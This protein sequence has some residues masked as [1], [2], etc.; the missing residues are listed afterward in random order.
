MFQK[1]WKIPKKQDRY[2][3]DKGIII[4][5][6]SDNQTIT[7]NFITSFYNQFRKKWYILWTESEDWVEKNN[8]VILHIGQ[9]E[10]E[11][12]ECDTVPIQIIEDEYIKMSCLIELIDKQALE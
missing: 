9:I 4:K 8:L 2:F 7:V 1:F 6:T 12:N 11:P 3:W 10:A 5:K